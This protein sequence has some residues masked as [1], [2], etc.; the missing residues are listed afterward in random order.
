[1]ER[2][3]ATS[4]R[5]SSFTPKISGEIL[6]RIANGESLIRIC[7]PDRKHGLPERSTVYDWL[8]S[9][10]EFKQAYLLARRAQGELYFEEMIDIADGVDGDARQPREVSRDRLRVETRRWMAAALAPQLFADRLALSG[11]S[12]T[13]TMSGL[14]DDEL[15]AKV[16]AILDGARQR[17]LAGGG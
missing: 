12:V 15:A 6:R 16:A 9:N 10:A 11:P 5:P 7:G 3:M 14:E 1:M 4:G 2:F 13:E 17:R 8:A